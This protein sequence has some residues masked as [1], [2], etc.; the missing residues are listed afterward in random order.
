MNRSLNKFLSI[1]FLSTF[2]QIQGQVVINEIMARPSGSQGLIL[3]N[4]NAG[5]EYIELYNPS[6]AP[7][8][9]SGYYIANRQDFSGSSGGSFRIPNIPQAIIPANGHLVL[10]TSA[11]SSDPNSIDIKLPDFTSNYCQNNGSQNFILAN[12]DGWVAL[13]D[14]NGIPVDAVYWS[15]NAS[16]ISQTADY[17]GTPCVPAGSPTGIT[18]SSAQLINSNYSGILNYVGNTTSIDLTFSRMPDGGS[19]VRDI[20]SSIN[21]LSGGNCNGGNCNT[22]SAGFALNANITPNTCGLSNGQISFS[23]S[24]AASYT[25]TWSHDPGL[26]VNTASNLGTGSYTITISNG[27]CSIDTTIVLN[28]SSLFTM[29]ASISEVTCAQNDGSISFNPSPAGSY[30]F[31]WSQNSSLTTNTAT[32]LAF[33]SYTIS[34]TNGICTVDT[35]IVLNAPVGCCTTTLTFSTSTNPN[36]VCNASSN[37]CNYSGP[38]ILINEINIYPT[39]GDGSIYGPGPGGAGSAEGEWIELFNP[40]WC[41]SIDISGYIL[42]SYNSVNSLSIPATEGMAFVIPSGTVV[43]PLGFVVVRGINAPAPP[44]SAI[45]IIVQNSNNNLCIETG[46]SGGRIWFQNGGGWF[47][48]YDQ[49]GVVQDVINWGS[50]TY[51]SDLDG[52]PCIPPTNN[53]PGSVTQLASCNQSGISYQLGSTSIGQTFVRIPDGGNWSSTMASENST[54]GSCNVPGGCVS[55]GAASSTCN[56][57]ATVVM[58]NGAAPYTYI[59]DDVL[60]QNS[61]TADSLCAGTY[62]VTIVDNDGCSNVATVVV[63]DDLLQISALALDPTCGNN[64]GSITIDATPQGNYEYIWS[65]NSNVLDSTTSAISSLG[66]G[67]YTLTVNSPS[68]TIDTVITLVADPII[69]D[70]L[71]TT[72]SEKCGHE[73]GQII[74]DSIVG[75]TPQFQLELNGN[76]IGSTTLISNLS[77]GNYTINITDINNC[78]FSTQT[79]IGEIQAPVEMELSLQSTTC[80]SSVGSI[81]V[82]SV[83][84]GYP[85][86]QFQIGSTPFSGNTTFNNLGAGNYTITVQDSNGCK[87]DTIVAI[88]ALSGNAISQIP[89]VIT[90][91]NDNVNDVW[92]IEGECIKSINCQIVNRWGNLVHSFEDIDGVWN[93]KNKDSE[94]SSGVYFYTA[95]IIF[96]DDETKQ[97]QGNITV[98]E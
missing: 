64:D 8:D 46:I 91:N 24:P 61:A 79:T 15:S 57:T 95:T 1:C 72:I 7:V 19:W 43:P 26:T 74:I 31:V 11:S 60:S 39:S 50:P 14:T 13:Y 21:D 88:V 98:I 6:C 73:D 27:S 53:L 41:D 77:Q 23:P 85:E 80:S 28:S 44:A 69:T 97:Y 33:G 47:A 93:G 92:R 54:Y 82:L 86:Y 55:G 4:G 22:S 40:D 10:G 42:G 62:H 56:G 96:Y 68:C 30:T 87:L 76:V 38:S 78:T 48:F 5:R 51:P 49:N 84:G 34:S 70:V 67:V 16:N 12:A 37:P 90:A 45:D 52:N 66:G 71:T 29:N 18:L 94:V 83:T 17:G 58:T 36:T 65:A 3:F 63:Q 89:N 2:I 32:N 35:T 75:G 59:W 9:V 81:E 25:Y 20:A